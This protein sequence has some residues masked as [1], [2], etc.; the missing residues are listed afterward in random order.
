MPVKCMRGFWLVTVLMAGVANAN[1]SDN[2]IAVLEAQVQLLKQQVDVLSAMIRTAPTPTIHSPGSMLINIA[3]DVNWQTGKAMKLNAGEGA[4][5]T[6]EKNLELN[7]NKFLTLKGADGIS[8]LVGKA[9]ITLK[10]NGAIHIKGGEIVISGETIDAK[11]SSN[12]VIKGSKIL[13]N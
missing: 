5:F 1:S 8:L 2:R 11:D 3:Q 6:T 7:A 4:I 9:S 10:K 12:T 13:G